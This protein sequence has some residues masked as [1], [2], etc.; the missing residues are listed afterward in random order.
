VTDR[1]LL[2]CGV[3]FISG[4]IPAFAQTANPPVISSITFSPSTITSGATSQMTITFG[5]SNDVAAILTSTLTD[6]L[7]PGMKVATAGAGGSCTGTIASA[8]A[9]S[10]SFPAQASIPPGGCTITVTVTATSATSTFFGNTIPAGTLQ[11]NLGNNPAAAS[12]TLTVHA[13][14]TV[15]SVV[16]KTQAAAVS[17]LQA[18]GLVVGVVNHVPS[19]TAPF[20]TVFQVTPA[21][22]SSVPAGTGVTISVSTGPSAS[23]NPNAPLTSVPGFVDPSQQSVAAAFERVCA[24]LQTPGLTLTPAQQNLLANCTAI[25]A[26][27]GGGVDQEGLK[28]TLDAISGKQ[29]TALQRAGVQFAGLQFTNIAQR[30]AQLRAGQSGASLADL[31]LGAP[32]SEGLN[33]LVATLADAAGLDGLSR[34]VG[35]GSGDPSSAGGQSRLGFFINGKLL[36]GSQDT[37]LNETG[38]DFR[39]HGVTAG[40]DYRLKDSLVLGLALGHSSGTTDFT[41]GSGRQDGRSNSISLY[42]SYY[43]EAFYVDLIGTYA[44]NSYDVD[45]TTMFEIT[46][47]SPVTPTNCT[48]GQCMIDTT[49]S[50]SARQYAFSTN[51]G[52]SF[53][54]SA[55]VI[56]PDLSV[57]YTRIDVNGFTESDSHLTGLGLAFADQTGTSLLLKAGAHASYA[58]NTPIGVILPHVRAHYIHEFKNDQQSLPVHFVDDPMIGTPTGPV[59][60]FVVF[61]DKPTRDYFDWAAGFSM[62]FAYGISAF[63]EYDALASAGA[64]HAHQLAFGIRF[65]PV[66]R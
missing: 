40:V 64:V 43:N 61:T 26:T 47:A 21:A 16:G 52:Y 17:A 34:L 6:T 48:A 24:A 62:Q 57:D 50:T 32:G 55:F 18:A 51:V 49:G 3:L 60:N 65:Q 30:L 15:P 33:Q 53:H 46:S 59:G 31:D 58:I 11:T 4:P 63:A 22:H 38:Y 54:S 23:T 10:I 44:H 27:H 29:S 8:G 37:T 56:G 9:S 7:P 20:G 36:R 14:V 66:S 45:R 19:P 13:A 25:F 2:L 35:G 1:V 28:T 12:G 39:S 5:N 42:G 41:D